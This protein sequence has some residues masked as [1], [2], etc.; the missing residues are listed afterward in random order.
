MKTLYLDCAMGAAGDMLAAA[1]LELMSRF[2]A[3][4]KAIEDR[5][6]APL[7]GRRLDYTLYEGKFVRSIAAPAVPCS[8]QE[9]AAAISGYV[10]LFDRMMKAYLGGRMDEHAIEAAYYSYLVN[11]VLHL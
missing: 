5:H 2:F 9:L 4:W 11:S 1:L 8:S 7:T 3:L 6:L 10:Q